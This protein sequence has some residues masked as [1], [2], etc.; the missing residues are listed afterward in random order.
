MQTNTTVFGKYDTASR[1]TDWVVI[2]GRVRRWFTRERIGDVILAASSLAILGVVVFSMHQ[3]LQSASM[4]G[5][6]YF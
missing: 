5:A 3:A 2:K 6:A 4:S 1:S